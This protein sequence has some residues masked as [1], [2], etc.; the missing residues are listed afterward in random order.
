MSSSR[1]LVIQRRLTVAQT[2][3]GITWQAWYQ[4]FAGI[5]EFNGLKLFHRDSYFEY[6]DDGDSPEDAVGIEL[7]RCRQQ[8]Q[9]PEGRVQ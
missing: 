6:F 3:N 7:E 8:P 9:C 5:A 1:N 2:R 4:R